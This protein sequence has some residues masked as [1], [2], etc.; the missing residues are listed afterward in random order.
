MLLTSA[1]IAVQ[2]KGAAAHRHAARARHEQGDLRALVGAEVEAVAAFR[3]IQPGHHGARCAQQRLDVGP[4]GPL[5]RDIDASA[6]AIVPSHER[7][8][9]LARKVF[10]RLSDR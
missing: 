10:G 8:D 5:H 6:Q 4:H 7:P 2:L 3:R 1:A 9:A